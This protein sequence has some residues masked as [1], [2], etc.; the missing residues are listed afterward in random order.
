[1]F[2]PFAF[3]ASRNYVP[4]TD[5]LGLF[6]TA[7]N[8]D[9]YPGTGNTWYDLSGNGYD[10]TLNNPSFYNSGGVN[11]FYF[12][13]D[14]GTSRYAYNTANFGSGMPTALNEFHQRGT[15]F[16]IVHKNAATNFG[17]FSCLGSINGGDGTNNDYSTFQRHSI[18]NNGIWVNRMYFAGYTAETDY[19]NFNDGGIHLAAARWD[20]N[21]NQ[22]WDVYA[23]GQ[24]PGQSTNNTNGAFNPAIVGRVAFGINANLNDDPLDG[25]VAEVMWYNRR[26]NDTELALMIKWLKNRYLI[27]WYTP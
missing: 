21:E 12:A 23:D 25:D 3:V 17:Y 26:L 2:S 4:V 14:G 11:Y 13:N 22:L 15:Y 27:P 10:F 19:Y 18:A 6:L 24:F 5:G 20:N 8:P 1:M 9:S 7:Q 16:Y